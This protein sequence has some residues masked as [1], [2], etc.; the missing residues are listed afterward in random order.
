MINRDVR[1]FE[2]A[3]HFFS[4][5]DNCLTRVYLFHRSWDDGAFLILSNVV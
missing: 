1:G 5:R 2:N 4:E 3:I